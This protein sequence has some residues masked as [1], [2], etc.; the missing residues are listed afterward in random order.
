MRVALVFFSLSFV[1]CASAGG[2]PAEALNLNRLGAERLANATDSDALD[3]AEARF[4]LALEYRPDF[5]EP[6][7]NLG[8]V[9]LRRGDLAAAEDHLR[10]AIR[11]DADFDEAWTNLGVVLRARGELGAAADAFERALGIDPGRLDARWNLALVWLAQDAFAEARAQLMRLAQLSEGR[12]RRR[13]LGALAYADLRLQR[14]DA[15][16]RRAQRVLA[17]SPD[18]PYARFVRGVV[19]AHQGSAGAVDDLLLAAQE[20]DLRVGSGV[21]L[22][23]IYLES[24]DLGRAQALVEALLEEAGESP[25]VRILAAHL[26]VQRGDSHCAREH[27]QRAVQLDPAAHYSHRLLEHID[28]ELDPPAN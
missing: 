11:L 24:R 7:A 14:P 22:A 4:R 18:E 16:L 2:L 21:R 10:A 19:R 15:A 28:R 23:A 8:V 20:P 12:D 3:D 5:A 13:V 26:C 1:A 9:M 25:A 6:R 17:R 27:A